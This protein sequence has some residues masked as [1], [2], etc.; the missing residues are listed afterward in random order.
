MDVNLKQLMNPNSPQ[1]EKRDDNG[2]D[3]KRL[4]ERLK[5]ASLKGSELSLRRG[6]SWLELIFGITHGDRRVGKW[7]SRS[8]RCLIRASC[9]N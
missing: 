3:R 9:R 2:R 5:K 4:K 1:P 7:G 8:Y 6:A